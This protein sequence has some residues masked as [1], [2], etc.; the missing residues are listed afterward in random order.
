MA[1]PAALLMKPLAVAI[2]ARV[3]EVLTVTVPPFAK[4]VPVEHVPGVFAAG[5][6]PLVV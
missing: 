6:V 5:V 4:V 2:A 1:L 3:S